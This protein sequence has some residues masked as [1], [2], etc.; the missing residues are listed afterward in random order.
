MSGGEPPKEIKDAL[1]ALFLDD[2]RPKDKYQFWETQPVSQFHEDDGE[3][4]EAYSIP[5]TCL[6]VI[7]T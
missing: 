4:R 1:S 7:C 2:S 5:V 3:V 6:C